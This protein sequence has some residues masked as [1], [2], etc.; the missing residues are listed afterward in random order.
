M[1][2][3]LYTVSTLQRI[4]CFHVREQ[5]ICL[6][7]SWIQIRLS[8]SSSHPDQHHICCFYGHIRPSSYGNAHVSH[9]KGGW[10][11]DTVSHHGDS[12]SRL[13][14]LLHFG[15]LVGG[16]HLRKHLP[17]TH[18]WYRLTGSDTQKTQF[19][20]IKHPLQ[21]GYKYIYIFYIYFRNNKMALKANEP[22]VYVMSFLFWYNI[23]VLYQHLLMFFLKLYHSIICCMN[24]ICMK[25]QVFT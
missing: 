6:R 7:Q 5:L 4:S 14:Q 8:N 24:S 22:L 21:Y 13:L 16:Q 1:W 9:G 15:Y 25:A 20:K 19:P 10:V 11:V 12:L 2:H 17:D 18:L 23:E 3:C